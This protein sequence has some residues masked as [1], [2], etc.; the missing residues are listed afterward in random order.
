M[1]DL[2]WF[3]LKNNK[4]PECNKDFTRNLTTYP[5]EGNQM[6]AHDCGFKITEQRYKEI[7]SG[8]I[9][10]SIDTTKDCLEEQPLSDCCGATISNG[11]CFR[12]KENC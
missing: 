11:L 4:C 1:N 5:L 10:K 7:V 12:C 3:N 8:M 2:K 9:E 6:L